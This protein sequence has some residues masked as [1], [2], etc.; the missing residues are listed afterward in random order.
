[1]DL[2]ALLK[3]TYQEG[4]REGKEMG[5]QFPMN[6]P[7]PFNRWWQLP[8]VKKRIKA[9]EGKPESTRENSLHKHIVMGQSEQLVCPI[10]KDLTHV[11]ICVCGRKDKAENN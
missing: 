7:L 11:I 10:C 6:D 2:K 4:F 9:C 8:A 5:K 3:F 1:M